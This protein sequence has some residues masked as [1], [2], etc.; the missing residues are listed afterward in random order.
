MYCSELGATS[1]EG[2][3]ISR[4]GTPVDLLTVSGSGPQFWLTLD[5]SADEKVQV[6]S[7]EVRR[8][9]RL[10]RQQERTETT[11]HRREKT[12]LRAL[13]RRKGL[14]LRELRSMMG[15][16]GRQFSMDYIVE[17]GLCIVDEQEVHAKVSEH[18][19]Q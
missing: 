13:A 5:G 18:F 6:M 2:G 4:E 8:L 15:G 19:R 12:R 9:R 10:L 3:G 17:A 14:H 11:H 7:T 1:S 16:R